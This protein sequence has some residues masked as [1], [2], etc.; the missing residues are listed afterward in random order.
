[1]PLT[2][3][4]LGIA[5]AA[6]HMTALRGDAPVGPTELASVAAASLSCLRNL[7]MMLRRQHAV[8]T[9]GAAAEAARDLF[10]TWVALLLCVTLSLGVNLQFYEATGASPLSAYAPYAFNVF[11]LFALFL[12]ASAGSTRS[13][14]EGYCFASFVICL[15]YLAGPDLSAEGNRFQ[16]LTTNPNQ[17][18]LFYLSVLMIGV[19]LLVSGSGLS[20]LKKAALVA[21][22]LVALVLGFATDSDAFK[23]SIVV[24]VGGVGI[25]S[26]IR[27]NKINTDIVVM[28]I[29]F[30]IAAALLLYAYDADFVEDAIEQATFSLTYGEQDTVRVLL[31][32]NGLLAWYEAPIFGNG[33][34]AWSGISGPFNATEA[35]NAFIDWLSIAGIIGM[36]PIIWLFSRIFKYPLS[37][38][39]VSYATLI[40][41]IAF[42][43]FHFTFRQP[44]YWIPLFA[45]LAIARPRKLL[46]PSQRPASDEKLTSP[47]A[48]ARG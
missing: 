12:E 36:I 38:N 7:P 35:H 28:S 10:R 29:L 43:F 5:L 33:P 46:G 3:I 48:A 11:V 6:T 18:A 45:A 19:S 24:L 47:A 8:G 23:I 26:A 27:L 42:A 44:F 37:G 25:A 14:L 2:A 16:G 41:L 40:A 4:L 30:G 22:A 34:G 15:G 31:W 20:N 9:S 21:S 32:Q 1:M 17:A 39:V 13:V